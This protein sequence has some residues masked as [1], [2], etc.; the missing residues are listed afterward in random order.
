MWFTDLTNGNETYH[1]G[2]YIELGKEQSDPDAEYVVD[3][4]KAF[5]PYCAYSA[6]YSC[7]IPTDEDRI[8]L[9]LRVGEMKYH[10]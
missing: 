10:E 9:A 6:L 8:P 4:N 3:L 7:A 2:R 1:V 5:N